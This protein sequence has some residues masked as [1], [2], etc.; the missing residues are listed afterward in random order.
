M[1]RKM[2]TKIK[3]WRNCKK[4]L[5]FD[6]CIGIRGSYNCEHF[7]QM[8]EDGFCVEELYELMENALENN[9]I[10]KDG[11]N[12]DEEDYYTDE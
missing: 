5:W 7:T 3:K 1:P 8:D 9:D 2:G 4:C 10:Y 11:V 12:Q 6:T